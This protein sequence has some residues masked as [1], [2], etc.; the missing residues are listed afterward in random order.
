M[1]VV[2]EER[3]IQRRP[4]PSSYSFLVPVVFLTIESRGRVDCPYRALHIGDRL[5]WVQK[6]VVINDVEPGQWLIFCRGAGEIYMV[7]TRDVV[8]FDPLVV[9]TEEHQ[10]CYWPAR[11][12]DVRI[13]AAS[14]T[15]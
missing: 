11:N 10:C 9:S 7:T 15:E 5:T 12:F 4:G 2:L 13:D 8:H 14:N 3:M 1:Q 6:L